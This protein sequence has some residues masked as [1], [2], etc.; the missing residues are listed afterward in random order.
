MD[1]YAEFGEDDL[2]RELPGKFPVPRLF[3]AQP[4]APAPATA[5]TG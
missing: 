1:T 4:E 3:A 2:M 5:T